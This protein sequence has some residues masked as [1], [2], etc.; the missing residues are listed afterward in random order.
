MMTTETPN[1]PATQPTHMRWS[2]RQGIVVLSALSG[3][4]VLTA[5]ASLRAQSAPEATPPEPPPWSWPE[6]LHNMEVLPKTWTGSRLRPVMTGFS[7][8]LGVGCAHCHVG[9]AGEPLSTYDFVSDENPNKDRAREMLRMLGSIN[10][11][12]GKLEPS[13]DERVNLWC[14]TC[15]RGRPR[16]MR[17][18]EEL[19]ETYRLE[20]LEPTLELYSALRDE[21]YGRGVY[22]FEDEGTLNDLGYARLGEDE[23]AAAIRFFLMNTERFPESA[24]VWDSLAEGYMRSGDDANARKYY[25]KSLEMDPANVNAREMLKKLE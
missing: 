7:R 5:G 6:K 18:S 20:G 23:T 25:R 8:A 21:F 22:D 2:R 3:V 19:D 1:G 16:P 24:N 13:G 11:H 15:H 10:D 12:L 9:A 4:L 17:L 14:H